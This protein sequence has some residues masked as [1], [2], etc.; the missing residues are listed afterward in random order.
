MTK[1]TP[2]A[3]V[4]S[5][6]KLSRHSQPATPT[7]NQT[8]Q[9]PAGK[10]PPAATKRSPASPQP[11]SFQK[12][13]TLPVQEARKIPSKRQH[14][15]SSMNNATN[16][17]NSEA[18]ESFHP[19][20]NDLVTLRQNNMDVTSQNK[21]SDPSPLFAPHR[22]ATQGTNNVAINHW[23]RA[24]TLI[25]VSAMASPILAGPHLGMKLACK[26]YGDAWNS[27]SR[28]A[29]NGQVTGDFA[30]VFNRVPST[31]WAQMPRGGGGQVLSHTKGNGT[32]R[33]TVS[34][35]QGVMTFVL[36]GSGFNWRVADIY[37]AGDDGRTVSLKSY[38]DAT[39][40][41]HEF[42]RDLKGRQDT[43]FY[44]SVSSSFRQSW[45]DLS[46][47][48]LALVREFI[49]G[50][51]V[52]GKPFLA[53]NGSTASMTVNLTDNKTARLQL[54][55]EGSWKIDDYGIESPSIS[56][57][58]FRNSVD[59]IAAIQRFRKFMVEP[60]NHSPVAFTKEGMLRDSLVKV[61]QIGFLPM[62]QKPS[63]MTYFSIDPSGQNVQI[64]LEDRKVKVVV[65]RAGRGATIAKVDVTMGKSTWAD[66]SHLIALNNQIRS[67]IGLIGLTQPNLPV[68]AA[69]AK[70]AP[71]SSDSTLLAASAKEQVKTEPAKPEATVAS[72]PVATPITSSISEVRPVIRTTSYQMPVANHPTVKVYQSRGFRKNRWR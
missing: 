67:G 71:A 46:G 18:S 57:A 62:K 47:E 25:A 7:Q 11:T 56:I 1:F 38:L 10:A 59:T 63:K 17:Q 60:A 2:T 28:G 35:S 26:H 43:Q 30:S 65:D 21:P 14:P 64:N 52:V 12:S 44:A 40:T 68:A 5:C 45:Q 36:V 33:V 3:S 4:A 19:V 6:E 13:Q 39:V 42:I 20:D 53:M 50:S 72:M 70:E 58:S 29:L 16:S 24:L 61:H 54:V 69:L 41:A 31:M 37:K 66:L 27:G 51:T 48:D 9:I 22:A 55:R 32:G 49:Q 8:E 23:V 15:N 34:T